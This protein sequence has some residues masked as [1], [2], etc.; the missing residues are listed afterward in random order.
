MSSELSVKK[1]PISIVSPYHLKQFVLE[2]QIC[3]S[4]QDA[5]LPGI[6]DI[7]DQLLV[8][9]LSGSYWHDLGALLWLVS[10]LHKLKRQR[11]A[12]QLLLPEPDDE[13]GQHAWDFLIRW[14]FFD[15][16]SQCVDDPAN[17]LRP[18]QVP[19]TMKRSRYAL[20]TG[21]DEYGQETFLHSSRILEITTLRPG[22][23]MSFEETRLGG[24]LQKYHNKIMIS[25][26]SR[27]CNWDY[28][29]TRAFIQRVL[30][31]GV[32]NSVLHSQGSFAN[33]SM[34]LDAKNLTLAI[35]DDG[36][37]IPAVL[38]NAINKMGS[39]AELIKYFTEPDSV[40]DSRLIELSVEKGVTSCL[41]RK[42]SGLYYLK[43]LVI[44]QGGELRIRSGGACVDFTASR[45][46]DYDD[47]LTSPGTMMRIRAPLR[48]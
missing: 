39:D 15:A 13:K 3:R 21:I 33:I 24:F 19:M 43:S 28:S 37:G 35:S 27:L 18:H 7:R 20:R 16:L 29:L 2:E 10:L 47:M 42:G 26:L 12:I 31:E 36:I 8:F 9:D 46:T 4:L 14:R 45:V 17:L 48:K 22:Q 38:R 44:S 23:Q 5:N 32:L 6:D 41:E 40:L 30:R 11:N 34:R 1:G 25:A